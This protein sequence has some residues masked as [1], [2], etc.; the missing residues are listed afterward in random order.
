MRAGILAR[1][2]CAAASRVGVASGAV[3]WLCNFRQHCAANCCSYA[4]AISL[5]IPATNSLAFFFTTI[6]CWI[7]GEPIHNPW[8]VALGSAFVILGLAVCLS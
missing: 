6:T 2:L 8:G 1:C 3:R 5:A 7:L 4:A